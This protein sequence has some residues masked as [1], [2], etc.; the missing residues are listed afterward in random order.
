M[1]TNLSSPEITH[2][3]NLF[4]LNK[5]TVRGHF[6][7][8]CPHGLQGVQATA[9]LIW[10]M[11]RYPHA[12]ASTNWAGL[13]LR[14]RKTNWISLC[15]FTINRSVQCCYVTLYFCRHSLCSKCLE[16]EVL[17]V[18]CQQSQ[19][20]LVEIIQQSC[21]N[22]GPYLCIAYGPQIRGDMRQ[23]VHVF[24]ICRRIQ[25]IIMFH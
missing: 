15:W 7:V 2:R 19:R 20:R 9:K 10:I 18:F 21:Q 13:V 11:F 12:H 3:P 5:I 25:I 8:R 22:P 1:P 17:D 14:D 23:Y 16:D 4:L 24:L 6:I